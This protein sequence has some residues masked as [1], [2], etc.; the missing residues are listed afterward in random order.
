MRSRVRSGSAES[1]ATRA[2]AVPAV[3]M[4]PVRQEVDERVDERGRQDGV[5]EDQRCECH[6]ITVPSP[7]ERPVRKLCG[8][9]GR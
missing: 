2:R 9:T 8:A 1:S 5:G 6:V 7:S 3:G 4:D